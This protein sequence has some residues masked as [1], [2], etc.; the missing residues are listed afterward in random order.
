MVVSF[1]QDNVILNCSWSLVSNIKFSNSQTINEF[2]AGNNSI[3]FYEKALNRI[4]YS[5]AAIFAATALV[6]EPYPQHILYCNG[7]TGTEVEKVVNPVIL[8][9]RKYFQNQNLAE[10]ISI[11]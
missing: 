2:K 5:L 4:T 9:D 1:S 7:F 10:N 11:T 3:R 6:L 8:D